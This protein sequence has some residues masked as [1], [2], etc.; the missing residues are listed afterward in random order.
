MT[1]THA[2]RFR[3]PM[4]LYRLGYAGPL[5]ETDA[6]RWEAG[7]W[8]E[9]RERIVEETPVAIVYNR[10]PH[11]VMMATPADLEDFTLGFSLTE[12]LIE[13]AD[14]LKHLEISRY[15]RGVEV[16]ATVD[17]RYVAAISERTRRL[18]GR[19]GCGICGADSVDVVLKRIHPVERTIG[20]SVAA[21]LH[22]GVTLGNAG[23]LAGFLIGTGRNHGA[24]AERGEQPHHKSSC[25]H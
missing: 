7:A 10:I 21:V 25:V 6:V 14:D 2:E 5:L 12:E 23:G 19:T 9:Q 22:M 17:E 15:S 16:Q 20:F 8:E 4:G 13:S 24:E 11:V 3:D 18:T 1:G